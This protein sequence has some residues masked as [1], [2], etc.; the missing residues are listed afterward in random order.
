MSLLGK[1]QGQGI[2][3]IRAYKARA[4]CKPDFN[5]AV[6][7]QTLSHIKIDATIIKIDA[8]GTRRGFMCSS[9]ARHENRT[10]LAG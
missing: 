5:N 7:P 1:W 3:K 10:P 4:E 9:K 2:I 6:C 8:I